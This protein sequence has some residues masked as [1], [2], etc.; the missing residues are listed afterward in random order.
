MMK[1]LIRLCSG[2]V[3]LLATLGSPAAAPVNDHFTNRT[4][5]SGNWLVVTGSVVGATRESQ[6]E[7]AVGPEIAAR[8]IWWSW[9]AAEPLAVTVLLES[10]TP[11][12]YS[13]WYYE[14]LG[15]WLPPD[16]SS[17]FPTNRSSAY[18]WL[19]TALQLYP[20]APTS[21]ETFHAPAGTTYQ[22]QMNST[23]ANDFRFWLIATNV[24]LILE[25]P[26]G[27]TAAPGAS[28]LFT[29][30]ATGIRPLGYQWRFNG[31][32]LPGKT[33][34]M[35]ALTNVSPSQAGS[36]S[37]V[38][39]N[40]TGMKL[41]DAAAL[42]VPTQEAPSQLAALRPVAASR[43]EFQLCGEGGRFYRIESTTNLV[44]WLPETSFIDPHS[45]F[46]ISSVVFAS[47]SCSALGI[48]MDSPRKFFRAQRYVPANEICNLSL[49]KI[50]VA[51]E[52]WARENKKANSNTPVITDLLPY[53]DGGEP[54]NCPSGG[55]Y[56]YRWVNGV[57]TCSVTNHV[58]EEP[59]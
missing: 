7:V 1:T 26:R 25:Q 9:T 42:N 8:T 38:V 3:L 13:S 12:P 33:A 16:L 22:I 6:H 49:K 27:V 40:V 36:Y 46:L 48:Q 50:R 17:G 37:V 45:Q 43:F 10:F 51:K 39:S 2:L 21:S 11:L 18:P 41:S 32:N 34:P 15:I 54:D 5:L 35:L 53:Y 19:V 57:P 20:P 59:R 58:L 30:F 31:T 28:A 55:W 24:P 44:N 4:V 56:A 52:M 14:T 23:L 47:N 29:V